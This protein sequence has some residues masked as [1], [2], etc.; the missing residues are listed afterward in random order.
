MCGFFILIVLFSVFVFRRAFNDKH[1]EL[2][3][4]TRIIGHTFIVIV[5]IARMQSHETAIGDANNL[6]ELLDRLSFFAI[7]PAV[8]MTDL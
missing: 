2:I 1:A 8:W 6:Q 7:A 4:M 5:V 3:G